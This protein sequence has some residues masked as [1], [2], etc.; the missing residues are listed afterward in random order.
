M[1]EIIINGIALAIKEY[2][3]K[4]VVTFRNI[5]EVHKRPEGTARKRFNDNKGRFVEG[6]DFFKVCASEI[7]THKLFDISP[8][9]HEDVTLITESGY[10][11]LVK[12]FTDDLSWD[13]QRQLVN[14]Y[15]RVQ[16]IQHLSPM[17]MIAAMANNAVET[18]RRL[19]EIE[20]KAAETSS[21]LDQA[22]DIF[23][24]TL[25][26]P[27]W[28]HCMN[29]RISTICERYH[30]SHQKTRGDLYSELELIANCN[31][32]SRV[33]RKKKRLRQAGAKYRD[34][35]AVTKLDVIADD[36]KLKPIFD[37]IVK[38]LEAKYIQGDNVQLGLVEIS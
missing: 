35:Q 11:M 38:K 26:E 13:V 12:S 33:I 4:R 29:H 18:E 8:K 3:G 16:Q 19:K 27:D 37:G 34:A 24:E 5:D 6:E 30:L 2:N 31:L 7:R 14:S 20:I 32:N 21:K 23:T 1:N 22:L 9:A 25:A 10:Y 28:K 36:Q 17:E 15:F